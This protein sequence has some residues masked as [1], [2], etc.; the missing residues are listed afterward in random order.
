MAP[1]PQ[2]KLELSAPEKPTRIITAGEWEGERVN[3][4]SET[5]C[6]GHDLQPVDNYGQ[7]TEFLLCI[8][9]LGIAVKPDRED[10]R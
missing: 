8:N 4:A 6:T 3:V 5:F 10:T 2:A 1:E 9:C 7:S